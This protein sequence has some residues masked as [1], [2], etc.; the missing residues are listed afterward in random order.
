MM[1][2]GEILVCHKLLHPNISRG[3]E[4]HFKVFLFIVFTFSSESSRDVSVV[5]QIAGPFL[6]D[7]R[8][9]P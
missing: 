1:S 7:L 3:A 4:L 5:C 2:L 6:P 8:L 9:S